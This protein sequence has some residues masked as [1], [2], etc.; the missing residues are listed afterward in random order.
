MNYLAAALLLLA[1]LTADAQS[2]PATPAPAPA[3]AGN[4]AQ[5][6]ATFYREDWHPDPNA[7][8][9]PAPP[10]RGLPSPLD[11]P[12]FPS[13]DWSYGGSPTIGEPDTG[14]YPLMT[15]INGAR[16]RT[17]LFGWID[18]SV[19][20]STSTSRNTPV[21]N[22]LY[23]N[24][25]ELNQVVLY[26]ERLPDTVQRDHIDIGYHLTALYGTDYRYTT[27]K[28]YFSSQ[29]LDHDRQYGFDPSL[30]YIDIY[31]PHIAQGANIRI[32]RFISIPGIEAQLSPNNY[33]FSHSLLY[34]V[35][36][37]T[38]TGAL[39]T[40]KLNDQWLIQLGITVSHDVAAWTPDA[41]PSADGCVS[42]TTRSVN[43]NFY[44]CANGINDGEYAF[45]NTQ[46]YDATWYHRF[47]KTVHIASEAYVM[48]QR[49]VPAV[50]PITAPPIT[51]EQGTNG[52]ICHRGQLH[53]LAPEYAVSNYI[54]KE[55]STHRYLS[56]R[57]D[58]LNDKK[59]QRTGYAGRYSENTLSFNQWIGSTIQL[60]PE[61]RFDHAW[62]RRSYD[63][64]TRTNQ[65]MAASDLIFHF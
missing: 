51:P 8:A 13:A 4:F 48:Y 42:Y 29:L 26:L 47:S 64:G 50:A 23:S 53:C 49:N 18:P 45:N 2:L 28:G 43:D 20:G 38:D 19:N 52:A 12:P 41:K 3:E 1:G 14:S 37:F 21:S 6:L 5:R 33:V 9:S 17:K 7:A 46:Q 56:F 10:R 57:T 15:A 54:Q 55:L 40:I 44:L 16:S 34:S 39:A 27:N 63:N 31:L 24:R 25:F 62:D 30:E 60:R 59:G 22:D 32:G 36:P 11:S 35:D 58:F 61:L 65:F